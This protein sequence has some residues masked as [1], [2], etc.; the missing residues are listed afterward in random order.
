MGHVRAVPIVCLLG[1]ILI[2]VA[3]GTAR[4]DA[5]FFT[6]DPVF[7]PSWEIKAGV[8]GGHNASGTQLTEVLDWNYALFPSL[9]LNLATSTK[10]V[11]PAG[12]G[13]AFGYADTELKI[14]WRFLDEEGLSPALGIALFGR[15]PIDDPGGWELL[16]SLGIIHTFNAH[17]QIKASV[18]HRLRDTPRGGPSPASVVFL[19][20]NF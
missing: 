8:S 13:H 4:A 20:W 2:A 14:K 3:P 19:V 7:S 17:W 6:D 10:H 5:P 15:A 11:R 16:T 18:S 12:D 9:R 1:L